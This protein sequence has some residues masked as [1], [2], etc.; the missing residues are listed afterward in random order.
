M[1]TKI[2]NKLNNFVNRTSKWKVFFILIPFYFLIFYVSLYCIFYSLSE[3]PNSP[4]VEIL[5]GDFLIYISLFFSSLMS[6][7]TTTIFKLNEKNVKFLN[8][9]KEFEEKFNK[10][11]TKNELQELFKNDYQELKKLSLNGTHNNEL[12][13]LKSMMDVK[14]KLI[15]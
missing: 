12:Y 8:A 15:S 6:L 5:L 3:N 1:K 10:I 11:T 14:Y 2:L 4:E 9:S 7:L 13:R